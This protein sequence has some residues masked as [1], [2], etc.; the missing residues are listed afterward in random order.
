[1]KSLNTQ[2]RKGVEAGSQSQKQ[3]RSK[4]GKSRM[5]GCMGAL[6]REGIARKWMAHKHGEKK[7]GGGKK[8]SGAAVGKIKE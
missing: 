1:L 7:E 2:K 6:R 4:S 5:A 3:R 8:K